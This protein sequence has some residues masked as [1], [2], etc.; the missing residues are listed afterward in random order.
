MNLHKPSNNHKPGEVG[1]EKVHRSTAKGILLNA[2]QKTSCKA[3]IGCTCAYFP[4]KSPSWGFP[5]S[6][7]RSFIKT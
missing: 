6:N 4:R 7:F 5:I 3:G 2:Y 1:A